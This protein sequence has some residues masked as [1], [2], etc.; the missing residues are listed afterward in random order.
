MDRSFESSPRPH[1]L[2]ARLAATVAFAVLVAS[3][4]AAGRAAL[5]KDP[6]KPVAVRG[7][8]GDAVVR[9]RAVDETGVP[10]SG[11]DVRVFEAALVLRDATD[12]AHLFDADLPP[13]RGHAVA[14]ADGTFEIGGL[15]EGPFVVRVAAAGRGVAVAP[16]CAI[17]GPGPA[18]DVTIGHAVAIEGDVVDAAGNGVADVAVSA[19]P[20]SLTGADDLRAESVAGRVGARTDSSGHFRIEGLAATVRGHAVEGLFVLARSSDGRFASMRLVK[21]PFAERARW[22]LGGAVV[23]EGTISE[24]ES[25]TPIPGAHV[26]LLVGAAGDPGRSTWVAVPAD[27]QGSFRIDG[28][29]P[30]TVDAAFL[31]ATGVGA[32]LQRP[33]AVTLAAGAPTKLDLVLG[34][35]R[36][37]AG[38]LRDNDGAALV[39]AEVLAC[40]RDALFAS[41]A[42]SDAEGRFQF[43]GL[44]VQAGASPIARLRVVA[45]GLC[46]QEVRF[47]DVVPSGRAGLMVRADLRL[48]PS[49]TIAGRVVDA[50][51]KPVA[52]AVVEPSLFDAR[53]GSL[54]DLLGTTSASDGAFVLAGLPAARLRIRATH[55]ASG[56]KGE[57]DLIPRSRVEGERRDGVELH[58]DAAVVVP[59]VAPPGAT[60]SA[61]PAVPAK[62]PPGMG[63]L[64]ARL[65]GPSVRDREN[66]AYALGKLGPTAAPALLATLRA[67]SSD[68]VRAAAAD[69]L[70]GILP[71]PLG[72][73][74]ALTAVVGDATQPISTRRAAAGSLGRFG[75][76]SERAI[77][78]LVTAMRTGGLGGYDTTT[79]DYAGTR[80]KAASPA[81]I[82]LGR[83]GPA[84]LPSLAEALGDADADVRRDAAT[85]LEALGPRALPALGRLSALLQDADFRVRVAAA[86]AVGAQGAVA[87]DAIPALVASMVS[88][89]AEAGPYDPMRDLEGPPPPSASAASAALARIGS[90]AMP[91]LVAALKDS[92]DPI[93]RTQAALALA[94]MGPA[95]L[96][97]LPA[98]DAAREHD[99][100]AAVR[101]A[102]AGARA[103]IEPR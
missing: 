44:P 90:D 63:A 64:L 2:G 49:W 82:A 88:T 77:P 1:R 36:G 69:A 31:A 42:T 7:H 13:D 97:A 12:A 80:V 65:R 84:A 9:G 28:V 16:A 55:A 57:L 48:Q 32:A 61:P 67:D 5:A 62:A 86:Q 30:G 102:A 45:P 72:V 81:A 94:A 38:R 78:A 51:G 79:G 70:G 74:D 92:A 3:L 46:P 18:G 23:V 20:A 73:V 26:T 93:A 91:P 60:P 21:P 22:V 83:I 87:K 95:A 27:D 4:V 17:V 41:V 66:A 37:I 33:S 71:P 43:V 59:E 100:D 10:V 11:A 68:A 15:A 85:G 101:Q 39:G 96:G 14:A 29:P 6:P 34:R 50:S 25:R 54:D 56:A 19:K 103:A 52:A 47:L 99:A 89:R 76:A 8:S 40:R 98:L 35:G 58:L 75:A 53:D 24:A